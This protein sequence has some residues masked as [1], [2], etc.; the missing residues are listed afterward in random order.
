MVLAESSQCRLKELLD[1]LIPCVSCRRA[2]AWLAWLAWYDRAT[3]DGDAGRGF[4]H[5]GQ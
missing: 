2:A 3:S 4:R 5:G 1:Y